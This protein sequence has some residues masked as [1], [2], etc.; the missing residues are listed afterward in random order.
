MLNYALLL[1]KNIY[2]TLPPTE[3]KGVTTSTATSIKANLH[4]NITK[5]KCKQQKGFEHIGSRPT[6]CAHS[7][8]NFLN[9]ITT[10]RTAQKHLLINLEYNKHF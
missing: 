5:N 8:D 1:P 7:I 10:K 6:S 4:V 9:G 2:K 3:Y